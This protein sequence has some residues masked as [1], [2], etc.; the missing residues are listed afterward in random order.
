MRGSEPRRNAR[1]IALARNRQFERRQPERLESTVPG[2]KGPP[3]VLL[4]AMD[5]GVFAQAPV[6]NVEAVFNLS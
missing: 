2:L 5:Q 1:D 4:D 6:V 3:R